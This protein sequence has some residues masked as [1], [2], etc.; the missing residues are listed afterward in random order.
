MVQELLRILHSGEFRA[1]LE[2]LGGYIVE[3]P[4]QVRQAF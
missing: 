1:R 3:H 2:E 4:G